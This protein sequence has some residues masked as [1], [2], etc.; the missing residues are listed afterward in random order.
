M[1]EPCPGRPPLAGRGDNENSAAQPELDPGAVLCH[2]AC[3]SGGLGANVGA[4]RMRLIRGGGWSGECLG[5]ASPSPLCCWKDRRGPCPLQRKTGHH[6]VSPHPPWPLPVGA[7]WAL[8]DVL[9]LSAIPRCEQ[10]STHSVLRLI[11]VSLGVMIKLLPLT[12]KFM[13]M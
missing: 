11:P 4:R 8:M 12:N 5:K 3:A 10:T 9:P 13:G 1:A 2:P 7:R 6:F